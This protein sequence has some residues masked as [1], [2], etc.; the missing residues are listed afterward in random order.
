MY[1]D[2]D[3]IFMI[4]FLVS[5]SVDKFWDSSWRPIIFVDKDL[6]LKALTDHLVGGSRVYLFDPY[7]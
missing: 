1:L 3:S 5:C 7:L 6:D 2:M 4:V